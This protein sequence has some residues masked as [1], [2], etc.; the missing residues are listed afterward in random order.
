[1]K[2][3]KSFDISNYFKSHKY[4]FSISGDADYVIDEAVRYLIEEHGFMESP[5]LRN[6]VYNS[7]TDVN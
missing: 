4:E 5:V 1:M 6:R 7:L 2:T 3:R